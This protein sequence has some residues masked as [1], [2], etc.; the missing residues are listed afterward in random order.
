M[1]FNAA[2]KPEK[3]VKFGDLLP[4]WM[5][6][7]VNPQLEA[8]IGSGKIDEAQTLATSAGKALEE[9]AED[10]LNAA[11][12]KA[13]PANAGK[14]RAYVDTKEDFDFSNIWQHV[15]VNVNDPAVAKAVN[16]VAEAAESIES[17]QKQK[18]VKGFADAAAA[19]EKIDVTAPDSTARDF[20]AVFREKNPYRVQDIRRKP[21][22]SN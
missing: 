7:H 4:P 15:I 14:S 22:L 6:E 5:Q 19:A 12:S 16:A 10:L 9:L 13:A 1:E 3:F 20:V 8:L 2:S 21:G 11:T 17:G 18:L